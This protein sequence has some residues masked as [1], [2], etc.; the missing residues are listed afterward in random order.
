MN[1]LSGFTDQ[2]RQHATFVLEDGSRAEISLEY[3]DQQ[4][5]WFCDV[6]WGSVELLGLRLTAAA[7]WLRTYRNLIPFG[8]AV[9]V[10]GNREPLKRT[11]LMDGTVKLYL[12]DPP[13]MVS[14]E[15]TIFPG[16]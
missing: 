2:Y 10:T 4:L 11:D 6:S 1:L 12:L 3:R 8:L 5:G 13:D 16:S 7:N 9:V 14:V 15:D